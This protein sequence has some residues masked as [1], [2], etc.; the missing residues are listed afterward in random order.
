MQSVIEGLMSNFWRFQSVVLVLQ[1]VSF[2][3]APN[4]LAVLPAAVDFC[5]ST[6]AHQIEGDNRNSDWWVF[7]QVPGSIKK[8][9]RSGKATDHLHRFREDIRWM[10]ELGVKRYRFSIE[11]ARL[12]PALGNWNAS[13]VQW[14][15]DLLAELSRAG[16][17]PIITLHHFT[18]PQ[19]VRDQG[20]WEWAEAPER[21]NRFVETVVSEIAPTVRDWNT[22]NEPMV[23]LVTGYVAGVVPPNRRDMN[24][25]AL[26]IRGVLKAHALAYATLHQKSRH[27]SVRVGFAHHLRVFSA[28]RWWNPL[29]HLIAYF[30][31]RAFN[32]AFIDAVETGNLN[33][34]VPGMISL[35]EPI[36]GLRA[37]ED[38]IGMNYY[39]RDQVRFVFENPI[40]FKLLVKEGAQTNDL[41]WEI[42][43]AGMTELL[44]EVS[45]RY[46]H[47]SILITENGIADA[48]MN[49]LKRIAFIEDH[50]K[51]MRVAI[52]QGARVETYCYWSLLDNFEWIEGF[53]PRFGLLHVNYDDFVRTPRTSFRW[54]QQMTGTALKK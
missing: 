34:S 27:S 22:F 29:D 32:W 50:W 49:D 38:F 37:T 48:S 28:A 11:W 7:E 53:D 35:S 42:Y 21:F 46:P 13:A 47:Q 9:E 26:A 44:I 43:P 52:D 16:I 1:G 23:H 25:F 19:W 20:G 31:D 14:Y 30:L 45:R 5:V 15:R 18:L 33:L 6:S 36:D 3:L 17:E 2:L 51:A 39:S 10:K 12:E 54:L 40:P 41:G 8:G 4:A 24:R